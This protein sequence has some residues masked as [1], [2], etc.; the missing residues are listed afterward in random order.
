MLPSAFI[1]DWTG[2]SSSTTMTTGTGLPTPD[3][4]WRTVSGVRI[5]PEAGEANTKK[6]RTIT[7][8]AAPQRSRVCRVR[9]RRQAATTNPPSPRAS[10]ADEPWRVDETLHEWQGGC[11]GEKA[12]NDRIEDDA[13]P[14]GQS[15]E[16][17]YWERHQQGE[18]D[19]Q[20]EGESEN[21][22]G[23]RLMGGEEG[24]VL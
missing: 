2:S 23:D 7:G 1:R 11:R 20:Q 15:H 16:H 6:A 8:T 9:K 22:E 12:K 24:Q 4:S 3:V 17:H 5:S 13:D 19:G 10:D 21:V 18:H 14:W